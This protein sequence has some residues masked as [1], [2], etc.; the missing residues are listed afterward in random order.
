VRT[1]SY[2]NAVDV[3]W[4]ASPSLNVA[5]YN[6]YRKVSGGSWSPIL[7]AVASKPAT[8]G[9]VKTGQAFDP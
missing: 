9:R 5:G 4:D 3:E 8:G 1:T 7:S 6:V 2:F